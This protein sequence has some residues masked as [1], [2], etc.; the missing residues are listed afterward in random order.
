MNKKLKKGLTVSSAVA[1][2]MGIVLPTVSVIAAPAVTNGWVQI[3]GTWYFYNNGVMVKNGW[4]KDSRGW[5]FLNAVDGSWVQRGWA[6]DSH[7]WGYI[8]NGYWVEHATWAQDST[9]W[10][11]IGSNGYWVTSVP[12]RATNPITEAQAAVAKA[13]ATKKQADI[14]A[15]QALVDALDSSLSQKTTFNSQIAAITA[16]PLIPLP[17]PGA[18]TG[19]EIPTPASDS[20]AAGAINAKEVKIKFGQAVDKLTGETIGNY[21]LKKNG[22]PVAVGN[23]KATLLS[24]ETTVILS[25]IGGAD[26]FTNGDMY[27]ITVNNVLTKNYSV[28]FKSYTSG[29]YSYYDSV[30]PSVLS[31]ELNGSSVRIYFSEPVTGVRFKVDGSP[32]IGPFTSTNQNGKYYVDGVPA[33]SGYKDLGVHNVVAYDATDASANTLAFGTATYNGAPDTSLPYVTNLTADTP[34]TFKVKFSEELKYKPTIEVKKS[35]IVFISNATSAGAVSLDPSDSTNRTYIV[36]VPAKD[37]SNTYDLYTVGLTY[38]SLS[39]NITDIKD[40]V[41]LAGPDYNS[42]VTLYADKTGPTVISS[43]FNTIDA[44][45]LIKVKFNENLI[46]LDP[47]K[48]KVFKGGVL[49]PA[50]VA[51]VGGQ[52][53]NIQLPGLPDVATYSIQVDAAAV[54]DTVG[55]D[56]LALST[57]AA[58]APSTYI[59][60]IVTNPSTNVFA[61]N[62]SA[63]PSDMTSSAISQ[64]YYKLD[65]GSLPSGTTV[66]FSG[67]NKH[68]LIT[69]GTETQTASTTGLLTITKNV[70]NTSN[71]AVTD[72]SGNEFSTTVNITDNTKPILKSGKY[73]DA[74]KDGYAEAVELTFSENMGAIVLDDFKFMVGS[75]VYTPASYTINADKTVTFTLAVASPINVTQ[76]S[77][78]TVLAPASQTTDP[79]T[80][81]TMDSK[82]VALNLLTSGTS[83]TVNTVK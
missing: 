21:E 23:L 59:V 33:I 2:G 14:D 22:N 74:A 26:I 16:P 24:D 30:K 77:T 58:Y 72:G 32:L 13:A 56:N 51:T 45:G 18:N 54:E 53:L 64:S 49:V 15:A 68:V 50:T 29:T 20:A 11:F 42:A 57:T 6:K 81:K 28:I 3:N 47:T 46:L 17:V 34:N 70:V 60:P 82:D 31:S 36:T 66:A 80:P 83:I 43:N 61:I 62:Y 27:T 63:S 41:N 44:T 65:G 8:E 71:K 39:V 5:C 35:N 48:V 4:A 52:Y 55:N 75:S 1:M 73:I 9:G 38:V 78:I 76:S 7:G 12:T 69:L 79:K 37:V 10:Q 25:D 40:T 19:I 67:D